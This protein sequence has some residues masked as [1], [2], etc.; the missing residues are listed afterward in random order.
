MDDG[1]ITMAFHEEYARRV[2]EEDK[3]QNKRLDRL[4]KA[5]EETHN[6]A[7]SIERLTI[8]VQSMVEEQ[9]AQGKRLDTL[10]ERD[11]AMWRKIVGYAVTAA[12]GIVIGYIFKHFGM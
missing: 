5:V 11:G 9:K 12:L 1:V 4:E 7:I 6:L 10:E 2:E 8:S 3:R